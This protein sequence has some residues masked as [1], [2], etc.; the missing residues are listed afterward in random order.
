MTRYAIYAMPGPETG[1]WQLGSSILGYDAMTGSDV[2]FPDDP[3]FADPLSL[4]WSAAP[5]QYGFHAT[6]KAPFR[7][8][9]GRTAGMLANELADFCRARRAISLDLTLAPV[10][11]FLALVAPDAPPAL[12]KLADD[13]VRHFDPF[14]EP[15]TPADRERRR[16]DTLIERQVENLDTWGYPFVFEDF[17]FHMTLTGAL[18]TEDRHK[19]EPVLRD[20]LRTVPLSLTLDSLALFR[21]DTSDSR[22]VV[23][24]R[25]PFGS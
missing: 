22:F 13:C 2:P 24:D 25:F 19:L 23:Q 7:L 8:A 3:L 9:E 1:L 21:Q 10:G 17:Q 14:R 16:P 4:A 18:D 11:H 12:S 20:L 15:L 5:R 6:L